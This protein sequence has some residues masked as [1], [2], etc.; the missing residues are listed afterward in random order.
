M[1]KYPFSSRAIKAILATTIAL[2]PILTITQVTTQTVSAAETD[3][4]DSLLTTLDTIN[5]QLTPEQQGYLSNTKANLSGL[6]WQGYTNRIMN[7]TP[8]PTAAEKG[9][10]KGLMELITSSSI[11]DLKA[12]IA[13]FKATQTGNVNTVFGGAVTVDTV[14]QFIAAIEWQFISNVESQPNLSQSDYYSEFMNAMLTVKDNPPA[15][16]GVVTSKF[17]SLVNPLETFIVFQ[18]ISN[19]ID[20]NTRTALIQAIHTAANP[21]NGG[22]PGGGGT[23]G[24][25][26][27][28]DP[29]VGS[30]VIE[31]PS[32]SAMIIRVTDPAGKTE[33][34]TRI[35]P[36]KVEEIVDTLSATKN[37]IPIKLEKTK[38]GETARTQVPAALFTK[39][40]NKNIQTVIEVTSEG[41]K[42]KLPASE[43]NIA[44]LANKLGVT[45][46][47]VQINVSV[48]TNNSSEVQ[49]NVTKN[50]LNLASNVIEF[51]V[52]AVSGSK[53]ESVSTFSTYVERD[54]VGTKNFNKNTSVAV[55]LND[56]GTFKSIPTVF[57]GNV[58]TVKSLT[59][60]NY[61]IVEN[62]KTFS[63]VS[64]SSW[65]KPYIDTLASKYI[66]YGKTTDKYDPTAHMTRAE[67]AVILV[68]ALGLP[69]KTYDGSF[70]DVRGTEW[71]AK[72]GEL[73][74]A[75][76][77]GIVRGISE[78]QF[79]P[80]AKVTRAQAAAMIQRAMEIDFL[81]YD[82]SQLNKSKKLTDFKDNKQ[83]GTWAKAGIEAVYQAGIVSG[84]GGNFDPNGY[85]QRQ[86]MAKILANFLVSA[87]LMN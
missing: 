11:L 41:A 1:K 37:I 36:E 16:S 24:G 27:P 48:N 83:I 73:T 31:L 21:D 4:I 13:T 69:T 77:Y 56:N 8:A 17:F 3:N 65:S 85:T 45:E 75:V 68:R 6:D 71:F 40:L 79:D 72:S 60:S 15:E 38:T 74:A 10:V 66:V 23:P 2:S 20:S 42:Y 78:D 39:S 30:N 34:V 7:S 32:G 70:K 33:V 46:E 49:A 80:T 58:A 87:K 53:I 54:I 5:G 62:S 52:E 82:Q 22:A 64:L 18:E 12:R 14:L 76:Q 67:F 35:V 63:D 50:K 9:L 59:N 25:G 84:K 28:V 55:K 26:T 86:E 47:Y 57:N 29:P 81:N 61:T 19:Q 51:K 43:L 44:A